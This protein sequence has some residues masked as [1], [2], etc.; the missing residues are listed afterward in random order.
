MPSQEDSL[1]ALL[2]EMSAQREE[3]SVRQGNGP[4]PG[5]EDIAGM[6]EEKIQE[7]LSAGGEKAEAAAGREMSE[8][9]VLGMAGGGRD[10]EEIQDL[11]KK[12]DRKEAI[13]GEGTGPDTGL[14]GEGPADRLFADIE[15]AGETEVAGNTADSRKEKALEKRRKKAQ[16]AAEKKAARA[17]AKAEKKAKRGRKKGS[18]QE[19]GGQ[20][21]QP[22]E[23]DVLLDKDLLDSIVSGAG[24]MEQAPA[25]AAEPVRAAEPARAE[26]PEESE[27]VDLMELAAAMEAQRGYDVSQE[28]PYDEEPGASQEDSGI[29]ALDLDEVDDFIPDI[30][31]APREEN[32]KKKGLISKFVEF[33]MEEEPENEDVPI[34]EENQDI[35]KELDKEQ[36]EK[37]K[38][39]K[40]K[41]AAKKKEKKKEKPKA[42]KPPKP[43]KEKKPREEE[44]YVPGKKLTFKKMLPVLLLGISFGAVVFIFSQL[45]ADYTVKQTAQEAFENGDYQVCYANLYGRERTEE[46]ERMYLKSECILYMRMWHQEYILLEKEGDPVRILDSLIQTVHDYPTLYE[47]AVLCDAT[48]DIEAVYAIL[49]GAM[50]EKFG[51]TEERAREI[52]NL[53]SNISYTRI[54]TALAEGKLQGTEPAEDSL[55][56]EEENQD[57]GQEGQPDELP[58]ETELD[59]E[60]FVDNGS[61]AGE[62]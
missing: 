19:S 12:S 27:P 4:A 8:E 15:R 58:E 10:L 2:K 25:R 1:D 23:Y 38:K 7:F 30:T 43:K 29:I 47:R 24:Q 42:P 44:P 20:D 13:A 56:A 11:L 34:S 52:G 14:Q 57:S 41:K 60:N 18:R 32:G 33:L 62:E 39:K 28:V 5:L 49:V 53:K 37:V 61:A 48:E 59:S 51:V 31:Q 16:A 46:E 21:G 54:V 36:A 50:N 22:Q 9:D 17:A 45:S 26:E 35:I 40:S 55:P 6:S 3:D